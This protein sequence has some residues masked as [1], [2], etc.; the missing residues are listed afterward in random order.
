MRLLLDRLSA[1]VLGLV[2]VGATDEG[3]LDYLSY[4]GS[5]R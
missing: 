3:A 2:A 4:A 5:E 1:P